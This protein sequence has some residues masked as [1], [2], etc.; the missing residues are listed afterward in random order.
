MT[1]HDNL[2][3]AMA[4][5]QRPSETLPS[6]SAVNSHC[7]ESAHIAE[8]TTYAAFGRTTTTVC[9]TD[10][11]SQHVEGRTLSA[12]ACNKNRVWRRDCTMLAESQT[13][14]SQAPTTRKHPGKAI[15]PSPVNRECNYRV[16]E[17]E[18][19]AALRRS[20]TG[21]K[22]T[23]SVT[24]RPIPLATPVPQAVIYAD[25]HGTVDAVMDGEPFV[26]G[27]GMLL[28]TRDTDG[29]WFITAAGKSGKY[30]STVA[31]A[32]AL[33]RQTDEANQAIGEM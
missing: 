6:H 27:A 1:S 3:R 33:L 17:A 4:T 9:A 2:G 26:L 31:Q 13:A 19:M 20:S 14:M 15:Q 18:V 21:H 10:S 29:S 8:S 12:F 5:T 24:S 32:M 25:S 7:A 23:A 11:H 16:A 28:A 22:S 30:A